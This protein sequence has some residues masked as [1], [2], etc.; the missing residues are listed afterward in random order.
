M[1]TLK[2]KIHNENDRKY[3][4]R[5]SYVLNFCVIPMEPLVYYQRRRSSPWCIVHILRKIKSW[6]E[7]FNQFN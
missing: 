1:I 2:I 6:D 4:S 3:V 5:S 7:N